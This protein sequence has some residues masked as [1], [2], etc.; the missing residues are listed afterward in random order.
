MFL[1]TYTRGQKEVFP[2]FP[3]LFVVVLSTIY[4]GRLVL[5]EMLSQMPPGPVQFCGLCG[6]IIPQVTHL[7]VVRG[8]IPLLAVVLIAAMLIFGPAWMGRYKR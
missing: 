1:D 8:I 7:D 4:V 6:P 3:M 5:N 2:I